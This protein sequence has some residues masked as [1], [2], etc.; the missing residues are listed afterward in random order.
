[1][2]KEVKEYYKK[3]TIYNFKLYLRDSLNKSEKSIENILTKQN[4]LDKLNKKKQKLIDMKL[5]DT[6]DEDSYKSAFESLKGQIE[7]LE[8]ELNSLNQSNDI[9]AQKNESLSMAKR[10]LKNGIRLEKFDRFVFETIVERV[11]VGDKNNSYTIKFIFKNKD[12]VNLNASEYIMATRKNDKIA[13]FHSLNTSES[14]VNSFINKSDT[15]R[16]YC[17]AREEK[18]LNLVKM[19]DFDLSFTHFSFIR[20]KDGYLDKKINKTIPVEVFIHLV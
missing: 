8:K 3:E 4:E 11:I 17:V 19:L 15:C 16:E 1:M 14:I 7:T 2:P 12:E 9:L 13:N 20:N 6:I 18:P 10:L 5:S